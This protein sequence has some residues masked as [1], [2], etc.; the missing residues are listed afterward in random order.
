MKAYVV[1]LRA[2]KIGAAPS[3]AVAIIKPPF[4]LLANGLVTTRAFKICVGKYPGKIPFAFR[5][6]A[7]GKAHIV[8]LELLKGAAP[9]T[10]DLCN[11]LAA[12]CV[13]AR[14]WAAAKFRFAHGNKQAAVT[15]FHSAF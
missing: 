10:W 13:L 15:R 3:P 8:L 1:G 12:V 6:L 11:M 5:R 9:R 14:D 4:L 7:M 2:L